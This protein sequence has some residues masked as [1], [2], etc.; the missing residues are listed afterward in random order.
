MLKIY[1]LILIGFQLY[2][3]QECN[4]LFQLP[5]NDSMILKDYIFV[6]NGN[7]ILLKYRNQLTY[8]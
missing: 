2:Y 1:A 5:G 8:Q 3:L 6:C 7:F 4:S